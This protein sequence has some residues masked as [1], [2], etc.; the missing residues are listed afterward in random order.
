MVAPAALR[1]RVTASLS[2]SVI[3]GTGAGNSAE[4]PP[5]IEREAQVVRAERLDELED[6]AGADGPGRRRLVHARPA[7]A[8]QP[9]VAQFADAVVGHVDPAGDVFFG[10][11]PLAEHLFDA[12][13]HA[14]ARLARPDHHDPADPVQGQPLGT[15][16]Q[17]RA[18]DGHRLAHQPIGADGVDSGL[19]DPHRVVAEL[20]GRSLH[21]TI[22]VEVRIPAQTEPR[23]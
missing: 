3:S 10:Q 7:R 20:F 14:R 16:D 6:F 23:P 2:A 19:P 22:P 11:Q 17:G 18:V 21:C 9:N 4:P 5:E 12:G 15:D 13:G 1:C 8:V